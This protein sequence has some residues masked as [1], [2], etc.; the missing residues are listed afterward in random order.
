MYSLNYSPDGKYVAYLSCYH[1]IVLV[2]DG[3]RDELKQI[4][5]G[6]MKERNNE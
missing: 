2:H 4:P 5:S 6:I 3:N 1:E